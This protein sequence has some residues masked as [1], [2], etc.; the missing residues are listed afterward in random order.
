MEISATGLFLSLLISSVGV[1][2]FI[3]GKKQT[4][5]PQLVAGVLLLVYPY[6]VADTWIMLGIAVAI[7][8][9][10]W[11]TLRFGSA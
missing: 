1:G 11:L 4:R 8:A 7:L 5:V 2:F 6:F 3:Y 9:A 10:L